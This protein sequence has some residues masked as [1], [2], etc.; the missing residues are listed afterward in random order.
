M[1]KYLLMTIFINVIL[2]QMENYYATLKSLTQQIPND[3]HDLIL[4]NI[5]IKKYEDEVKK[6]MNNFN[7][8]MKEINKN[9]F[10][11]RLCD[12]FLN[13][14]TRTIISKVDDELKLSKKKKTKENKKLLKELRYDIHNDVM[15]YLFMSESSNTSNMFSLQNVYGT[16][17]RDKGDLKRVNIFT[18]IAEEW[19]EDNY[20]YFPDLP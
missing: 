4:K 18:E 20:L 7:E 10:S 8:V 1:L 11:Y 2:K 16:L 19:D 5:L 9:Q 3:F 12:N 15:K 6:N 13:K 14:L 17:I